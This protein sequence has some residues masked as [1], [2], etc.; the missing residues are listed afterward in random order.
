MRVEC[1]G[2]ETVQESEIITDALDMCKKCILADQNNG[3]ELTANQLQRLLAQEQ[4]KYQDLYERYRI[5]LE[6]RRKTH[7]ELMDLKGNIRVMCRMR[8]LLKH[9]QKKL[10][11]DQI[12]NPVIKTF[13]DVAI[14]VYNDSNMRETEYEFTRVFGKE[15]A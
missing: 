10:S 7:N 6:K 13:E 3:D 14:N 8:P 2:V 9:E 12:R 4:E 11:I 5:E 15:A 1:E